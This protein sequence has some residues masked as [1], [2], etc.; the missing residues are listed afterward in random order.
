MPG[1][2]KAIKC[3]SESACRAIKIEHCDFARGCATKW[4][5]G[6]CPFSDECHGYKKEPQERDNPSWQ[7]ATRLSVLGTTVIPTTMPTPTAA[8]VDED[9]T[10]AETVPTSTPDADIMDDDDDVD[11]DIFFASADAKETTTPAATP[12]VA[13]RNV[14]DPPRRQANVPR[15]QGPPSSLDRLTNQQELL[16]RRR[17]LAYT[18]DLK[19]NFQPGMTDFRVVEEGVARHVQSSGGNPIM[20]LADDPSYWCSVFNLTAK[21]DRERARRIP[22]RERRTYRTTYRATSS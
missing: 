21:S 18:L 16:R 7:P 13:R 8:V 11:A 9:D 17:E 10:P 20:K 19:C 3:L 12:N 1:G 2:I 6:V 4:T 5:K 14:P 15:S 22:G